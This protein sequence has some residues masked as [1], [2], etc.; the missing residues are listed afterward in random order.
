MISME[1]IG[2]LES[3]FLLN[4]NPTI[5]VMQKAY[6]RNQFEFYGIRS[7]QRKSLQ[8]PFLVK[9]Y[10][11][12][13]GEMSEIVML[14]WIKP[15]RDFQYFGQEFAFKYIKKMELSDITLYEHMVMHKSW[16]DTIDFIAVNLMGNYFKAFPELRY[17]YIQKWLESG[18]IWLQRSA[19]L[20]QL[21]YKMDIDTNLLSSTISTLL[22]TK[23]FF[24]DKAIGWILRE[25]S[26]SNQ[27]WVKDFVG[28]T[29]LS[30][31]SKREALRLMK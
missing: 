17:Q 20:F 10:L 3:E 18:D 30:N 22:G 29:T 12:S 21:K 25:Y 7:P 9:D 14:L 19:L 15:Q 8:R 11:P 1:Y 28:Y 6:M 27:E 2:L 5:A 4:A 26:K 31:L 24:I 16:W 23:E 13:K